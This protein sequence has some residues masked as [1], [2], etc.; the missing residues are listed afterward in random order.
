MTDRVRVTD[1]DVIIEP[2]CLVRLGALVREHAPAHSYAL[3]AD[4]TVARL[5]AQ[6]AAESIRI[7]GCNVSIL[8]FPAGESY[9]TSRTWETL[10]NELTQQQL[11]RDTCVIAL[12]GGVTGDLAGFVAATYMRGIPV[13]QVPTTLLAMVDASI[14]G[15]TGIDMPAGKNLVG[16]FHQPALVVIDPELLSTLPAPEIRNGL[17]EA[18]KHAAIFDAPHADWIAGSMASVEQR[19]S[20]I[21]ASLIKRSVEIKAHFVSQDVREGGA[22]AALNFGH[23]IG[24]AIEHVSRYAVPHGHAV[25]VG[26][27]VETMAG[28]AAGITAPGTG[29][30]L[31]RLLEAA[32]L[33]VRLSGIGAAAVLEAAAMDKKA[34]AGTRRYTLL[35][36]LGEVAREE[37][38]GWTRTLP[39]DVVKES[40]ARISGR[41]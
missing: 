1:Y 22:R 37:G 27:M 8:D 18:I 25:A 16:A 2:G 15:K 32:G 34:R 6:R 3:I 24:H 13:V 31:E 35:A 26:M 12:G 38:G 39:D 5:Y 10:T 30:A 28:E 36:R 41:T 40:L 21:L 19:D 9:K 23:T 11:G 17:A 4:D 20:A 29:E 33:P 7:A 14:G